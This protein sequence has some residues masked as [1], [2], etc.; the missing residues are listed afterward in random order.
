METKTNWTGFS[1][2]ESDKK[3]ENL[4]VLKPIYSVYCDLPY[5]MTGFCVSNKY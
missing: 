2:V 3:C 5:Y 4:N 1:C